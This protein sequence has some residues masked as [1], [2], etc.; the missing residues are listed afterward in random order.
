[1]SCVAFVRHPRFLVQ[2]RKYHSKI[3]IKL[4]LSE[5]NRKKTMEKFKKYTKLRIGEQNPDKH[6]AILIPICI[7]NNQVSLLYTIR[8][9]KLKS[10]SGQVCFPGKFGDLLMLD[11]NWPIIIYWIRRKNGWHWR[12][13]VWM[14]AKRN[15]RGD[16]TESR[17]HW[18]EM[19][20]LRV[21]VDAAVRGTYFLSIFRFGALDQRWR[22]ESDHQLFP[23]WLRYE[24]LTFH[25][26]N[27]IQ[28][29]WK[30]FLSFLSSDLSILTLFDTHNSGQEE[31]RRQESQC[32][33]LLAAIWSFGEWPRQLHIFSSAHFFLGQFT[34]V[35]FPF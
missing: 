8:S 21:V 13:W 17:V 3:D 24:T 11:Y 9:S 31:S 5:E 22:Q 7:S 1:M 19:I 15:W 34:I 30:R 28:M 6:A 2:T 18:C 16:W 10:H 33:C 29:R 14:R 23:L 4:L 26:W 20:V 27:V 25:S 12:T 35:D 32:Q